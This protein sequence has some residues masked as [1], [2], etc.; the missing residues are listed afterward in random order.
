MSFIN[1][2]LWSCLILCVAV[3]AVG[4]RAAFL[5]EGT[6]RS[7]THQYLQYYLVFLYVF[8]Y[9]GIWSQILLPYVLTAEEMT[10][11][12]TVISQLA[13]PFYFVSLTMLLVWANK[14]AQMYS[15]Y[16]VPLIMVGNLGLVYLYL[17]WQWPVQEVGGIVIALTGL[18]A[19]LVAAGILLASKNAKLLKRDRASIVPIL[20]GLSLL[21]G[22]YFTP[23][24][25][26][27]VYL[28]INALLLFLG[29]TAVVVLSPT[30][31]PEQLPDQSF[32]GFLS[33]H[34]ISEREADVIKGI[35]AGKTN[36]EIANQLFLG[37]Q[38]VKDHASRIYRKAQ[39]KNR[40]QLAAK[41]RDYQN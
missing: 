32:D 41:L 38:T 24:A 15:T 36:Q 7:G 20:L 39:V 34:G 12:L 13:V 18:I 21:H 22:S 26:A 28:P 6:Q 29:N 9:Y 33:S 30:F 14:I 35:Y 25:E 16:S 31:T 19:N 37:L 5:T 23:W 11:A 8:G 40:S 17:S 4:V 3:T 1:L 10:G 27:A 2:L